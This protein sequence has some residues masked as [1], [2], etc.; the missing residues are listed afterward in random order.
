MTALC[1]SPNARPGKAR[2][3]DIRYSAERMQLKSNSACTYRARPRP[4]GSGGKPSRTTGD[5]LRQNARRVPE[6]SLHCVRRRRPPRAVPAPPRLYPH[7]GSEARVPHR[8]PSK[9]PAGVVVA[10]RPAPPS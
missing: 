3:R 6:A 2:A 9:G 8:T 5:W 4:T 10:A 1:R 7:S